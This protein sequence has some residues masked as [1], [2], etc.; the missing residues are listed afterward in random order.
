VGNAVLAGV[1]VISCACGHGY[2]ANR[3][4]PVGWYGNLPSC[5]APRVVRGEKTLETTGNHV[6]TV[7]AGRA[8]VRCSEG[9]RLNLEVYDVE[10]LVIRGPGDLTIRGPEGLGR[11]DAFYTVAV[12]GPK[13]VMREALGPDAKAVPL[14]DFEGIE[15]SVSGDATIQPGYC[16]D[17]S[18]CPG[19]DSARLV[20]RRAQTVRIEVRALGHRASRD[21]TVAHPD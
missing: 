15:W 12:V 6:R 3:I 5:D 10:G 11:A 13:D 21:V 17:L 16:D 14:T 1:L 2:A 7:Q 20:V 9:G 4:V 19:P 8:T 18:A